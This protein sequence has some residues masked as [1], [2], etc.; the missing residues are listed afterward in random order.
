MVT[1]TEV[2][3]I[4]GAIESR[5]IDMARWGDGTGRHQELSIHR[6]QRIRSRLEAAYARRGKVAV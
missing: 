5:I 3:E 1:N 6:L 4:V 2:L